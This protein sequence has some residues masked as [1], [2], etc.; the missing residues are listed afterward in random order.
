MDNIEDKIQ[1]FKE[2]LEE[3]NF[4][5]CKELIIF[6]YK[7]DNYHSIDYVRYLSEE[8]VKKLILNIPETLSEFLVYRQV[9]LKLS[10]LKLIFEIVNIKDYY[11]LIIN[12]SNIFR[13]D[14]Y[15]CLEYIHTLVDVNNMCIK[16][17]ILNFINNKTFHY[18]EYYYKNF[19]DNLIKLG[20]NFI[21][22]KNLFLNEICNRVVYYRDLPFIKHLCKNGAVLQDKKRKIR[23]LDSKKVVK[24]LTEHGIIE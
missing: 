24:Y 20:Y 9:L 6:D 4:E 13:D 15:D 1:K 7:K 21:I 18:K 14:M 3:D 2:A 23:K 8:E 17:N 22:D 16:N 12:R 5:L 11:E 19:Y 10:K